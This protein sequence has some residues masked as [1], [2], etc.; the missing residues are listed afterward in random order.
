VVEYSGAMYAG[1]LGIFT[2]FGVGAGLGAGG[3]NFGTGAV[4]EY[5]GAMYAGGLGIFTGFGVGAGLGAGFGAG[6]AVIDGSVLPRLAVGTSVG[7][8]V[9]SV[10]GVGVLGTVRGNAVPVFAVAP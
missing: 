3:E 10:L 8:P 2:G 9:G 1:G 7:R 4:V 5:S 6:G